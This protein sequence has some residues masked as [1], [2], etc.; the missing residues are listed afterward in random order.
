[1]GPSANPA[2]K[3][4]SGFARPLLVI[5][6]FIF[7]FIV[8]EKED[9]PSCQLHFHLLETNTS[10]TSHARKGISVHSV[11]SSLLCCSRET[12]CYEKTVG[13]ASFF[14]L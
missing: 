6:G 7:N 10:R 11:G 9:Q 12:E 13:V 14:L 1:M 3:N 2:G 4:K 5:G 8:V